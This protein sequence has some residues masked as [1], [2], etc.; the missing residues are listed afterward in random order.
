VLVF[1]A[2]FPL[3]R[4]SDRAGRA[5]RAAPRSRGRTGSVPATVLHN[6]PG[7]YRPI[8]TAIAEALDGAREALDVVNPYVTDRRMIGRIE[9]AARRGVEVRLFVPAKAD[10]WACAAA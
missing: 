6:A 1:L 9:G 3:A 8:T 2:T 10:N 4:G 7:R 5:R